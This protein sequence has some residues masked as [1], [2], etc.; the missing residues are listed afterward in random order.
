MVLPIPI[1]LLRSFAA[2]ETGVA[3]DTL[4]IIAMVSIPIVFFLVRYSGDVM[5]WVADQT[6]PL[7]DEADQLVGQ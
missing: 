5:D 4:L 3:V 2:D 6:P 7:F 1:K